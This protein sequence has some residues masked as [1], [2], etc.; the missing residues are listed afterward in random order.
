M[1]T[2]KIAAALIVGSILLASECQCGS[3]DEPTDPVEE[4][5]VSHSTAENNC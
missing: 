2:V 4:L 5:V 3:T 1:K